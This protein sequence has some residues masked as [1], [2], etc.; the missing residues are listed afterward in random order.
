MTLVGL[1]ALLAPAGLVDVAQRGRWEMAALAL[2]VALP[3]IAV[4]RYG[5]QYLPM[6]MEGLLPIWLSTVTAPVLAVRLSGGRS[7]RLRELGVG[8]GVLPWLMPIVIAALYGA[9]PLPTVLRYTGACLAPLGG[10]AAVAGAVQLAR[11][12]RTADPSDPV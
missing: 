3:M 1:L 5:A 6:P 9:V 11:R 12:A 4:G 8:L 10:A 7:D 2:A